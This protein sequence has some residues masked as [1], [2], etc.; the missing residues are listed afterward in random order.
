MQSAHLEQS[1]LQPGE[2]STF[3]NSIVSGTASV[4]ETDRFRILLN[5]PGRSSILKALT[6]ELTDTTVQQ[7]GER[8]MGELQSS[9]LRILD[10]TEGSAAVPHSWQTPDERERFANSVTLALRDALGDL[11]KPKTSVISDLRTL[12]NTVVGRNKPRSFVQAHNRTIQYGTG[13]S[14]TLT[15][16][17]Q[18][19]AKQDAITLTLISLGQYALAPSELRIFTRPQIP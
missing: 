16:V 4:Q 15:G 13:D 1:A 5:G 12:A 18:R 2:A 8:A 7:I 11:A 9:E 3:F 6:D 14:P 10:R 17:Q 19:Q